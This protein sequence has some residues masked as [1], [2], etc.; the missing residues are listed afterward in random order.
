M[1]LCIDLN[2]NHG[3]ISILFTDIQKIVGASTSTA[4]HVASPL[5][6][7]RNIFVCLTDN[8]WSYLH[9][10]MYL[11]THI[12]IV[13]DFRRH[14]HKDGDGAPNEYSRFFYSLT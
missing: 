3:E 2:H 13:C 11:C 8:I 14:I 12:N 9:M 4:L 10:A 7:E 5:K 1:R 6:K